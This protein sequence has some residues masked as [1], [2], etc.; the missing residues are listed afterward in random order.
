MSS[1]PISVFPTIILHCGLCFLW[2]TYRCVFVCV[3]CFFCFLW[4]T[5]LSLCFRQQS[6]TVGCVSWCPGV[7]AMTQVGTIAHAAQQTA[8]TACSVTHFPTAKNS[9]VRES[10][11]G[12]FIPYHIASRNEQ[13][14]RRKKTQCSWKKQKLDMLDDFSFVIHFEELSPKETC[15]FVSSSFWGVGGIVW[16][17]YLFRSSVFV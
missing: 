1:L 6:C 5:Y 17:S 13:R 14:R 12:K 11:Q 16:N 2:T 4:T 15:L 8:G 9:L 3:F 7:Q 10:S